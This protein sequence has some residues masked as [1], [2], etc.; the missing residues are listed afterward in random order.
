[1]SSLNS[2]AESLMQ[3]HS[4][5]HDRVEELQRELAEAN[6]RLRRSRA[7][8]ALGEM[9]AGIAHEIRNPL[10]SI[11]LYVQML[12][13]DVAGQPDQ[14]ALCEKVN[15]AVTAMDSIVRDVLAFARD[16]T[17]R[18]EPVRTDVLFER[19]LTSCEGIITT[20]GVDV[21]MA[22]IGVDR[23]EADE[24]LLVQA[25]VNVLANAIEAM[26][27]EPEAATSRCVHLYA[28]RRPVR[29]P[30][31]KRA[32]RVVLGVGDRG[33]GL[34][35]EARERMFNPFFTT[36]ASG[37]GL[38]LAI[39]HRIV[40]AHGGHIEVQDREGGGALVELCLPVRS[41]DA[42]SPKGTA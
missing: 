36:R 29:C 6:A 18:C 9:A 25:V 16:T 13:E 31:G 26:A 41:S 42:A 33:P 7:L 34:T 40:D 35:A 17:I 8:A 11:R 24:S 37:T 28:A 10:G 39:V 1:M 15:G 27:S 19:A 14:S 38:G 5:L 22:G 32:V 4:V 3:T 23:F 21:E 20:S 2:T 30:G 12:A